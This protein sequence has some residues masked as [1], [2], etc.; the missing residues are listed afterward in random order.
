MNRAMGAVMTTISRAK[1]GIPF[2]VAIAIAMFSNVAA[3]DNLTPTI[4]K[5][6][7]ALKQSEEVMNGLD[8][9]LAVPQEWLDGAMKEGT[10]K[11]TGTWNEKEFSVLNAPFAE[12]FPKIKVVYVDG[13]TIAARVVATLVAFKQKQYLSDVLTGFGGAALEFKAAKALEDVTN[14]PGY[15]NTVAG[16]NDPDGTWAAL[17][18]RY[19]CI[20][21]NKDLVKT[22]ELPKTWD[23][24][25]DAPAF[26]NGN[27]AI[28][29]RPQLWVQMLRTVKGKEW[30]ESFL[31]K[32][33]TIVKPQFRNE[34]MDALL[35]LIAAGEVKAALPAAEYNLQGFEAKGA[36]VSWHCPEPVPLAPSQLGIMAG[37]PHPNASRVW[38]NWM[39]SREGQVAAFMADGSPPS[40]KGLQTKDF[41]PYAE[42]IVGRPLALAEEQYNRE[43]YAMWQKYW[44]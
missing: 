32:F 16:T 22:S 39:L 9:D 38:T 43:T 28:G 3:A 42:Q 6:L 40:H 23:D 7:Q 11:V 37:N 27:L 17:R 1:C 8:Q 12:R 5:Y 44:K 18:M 24:L 33:F 29:N 2:C 30:T 26:R 13:G 31:E 10:V 21:Y 14:L 15:K 4:K 35:A 36:P 19:W 41:L 20:G 25:L 34:G